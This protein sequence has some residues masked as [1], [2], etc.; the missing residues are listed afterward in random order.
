MDPNDENKDVSQDA[1]ENQNLQNSQDDGAQDFAQADEMLS[2]AEMMSANFTWKKEE[3]PPQ[4]GEKTPTEDSPEATDENDDGEGSNDKTQTDDQEQPPTDDKGQSPDGEKAPED[5]WSKEQQDWLEAKGYGDVPFSAPA[6][7]LLQSSQEAEK[8]ITEK[9]KELSTMGSRLAVFADILQSGDVEELG[10][11]A[12]DLGADLKLDTKTTEDR[13]KEVSD[14]YDNVAGSFDPLLA[15]LNQQAMAAQQAGNVEQ[16]NLIK[17]IADGIHGSLGTLYDKANKEVSDLKL[18]SMV[19]SRV[20]SR[21]GT[22]SKG[23]RTSWYDNL[24]KNAENAFTELR[25]LDTNADENIDAV[26]E[27]MGPE[28]P[29]EAAGFSMAKLFGSSPALAQTGYK[30]GKALNLMKQ[31]DSGDLEKGFLEKFKK[32]YGKQI[33]LSPNGGKGG[34]PQGNSNKKTPDYGW[35]ERMLQTGF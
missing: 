5:K 33:G 34:D 12:K 3:Q 27:V 7:K 15:R 20:N 22:E 17:A 23:K 25:K 24:S 26:K 9:S 8:H 21:L 11:L 16:V 6:L 1:G 28:S 10:A 19:D 2:E 13:I 32:E 14:S 30:I 4:D 29:F 18:Q 31:F 35:Q